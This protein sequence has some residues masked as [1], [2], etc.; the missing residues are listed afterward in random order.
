MYVARH[1]LTKQPRLAAQHFRSIKSFQEFALLKRQTPIVIPSADGKQ[2]FKATFKSSYNCD[3]SESPHFPL[4]PGTQSFLTVMLSIL[5]EYDNKK[6]VA[7]ILLALLSSIVAN[8]WFSSKK[9]QVQG[10]VNKA[11]LTRSS[12]FQLKFLISF[13]AYLH[14][15]RF[16]RTGTCCCLSIRSSGSAYHHCCPSPATI[17]CCRQRSQGP[18]H[19]RPIEMMALL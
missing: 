17:G 8:M 3:A 2:V 12:D 4:K 5:A 16:A 6:L 18:F 14:Y 13:E 7:G 10:K 19:Y 1:R 11:P 9:M 15:R